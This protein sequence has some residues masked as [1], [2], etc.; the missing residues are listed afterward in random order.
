LSLE[1]QALFNSG[2]SVVDTFDLESFK[3]TYQAQ[4]QP[5]RFISNITN[6]IAYTNTNTLVQNI[7]GVNYNTGQNG[8]VVD[9]SNPALYYLQVPTGFGL[10][11]LIKILDESP[12]SEESDLGLTLAQNTGIDLYVDGV[13]KL[14]SI[15]YIY[16]KTAS[17]NPTITFTSGNIPEAGQEIAVFL[18]Y[19]NLIIPEGAGGNF[20]SLSE[21]GGT[22][23]IIQ[24]AGSYTIT[25][26][27]SPQEL[28][29]I[30][31]STP[32]AAG[33]L[34]ELRITGISTRLNFGALKDDSDI[35]TNSAEDLNGIYKV[36]SNYLLAEVDGLHGVPFYIAGT[37]DEIKYA[38]LAILET[39]PFE[40]TIDIYYETATQGLISS[41]TNGVE[42]PINYY[43]CINLKTPARGGDTNIV[44]QESRIKGGFNEPSMD[45]GVQAYLANE[46]Y[47]LI[48]RKSSLIY[49]GI[50][51][52]NTKVNNTNQFPSGENIVRTLDPVYG[53]IQKLY[54]D[55][56]DLLIFQEEKV[57]QALIDKD[58]IYTAEGQAL[59]TAGVNVIS[60]VNA[61]STNYGI[62]L[63]PKSFAVYAGRKYFVDKP[64]GAV[65]RLSRDG[66][67][68]ISN[69]GMRSEFRNILSNGS[70]DTDII[71]SWDMYNKEYVLSIQGSTYAN[72]EYGLPDITIGI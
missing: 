52:N 18:K 70:I 3:Y 34:E 15:D 47:G 1:N 53:S 57:S 13:K 50:L 67:T 8:L 12:F 24:S 64:K 62:G 33:N 6:V 69:Y 65:L 43:N 30:P 27:T 20:L 37:P 4:Q 10:H 48:T 49:S 2:S 59:T 26:P 11:K 66:I 38:D 28:P 35:Y 39:R 42:I 68:E 29:F 46:D 31:P 71:G 58:V 51:N 40:S 45:Y 32:F 21:L 7:N 17:P 44:W 23:S 14:G 55:T 56:D 5:E 60:Q 41:L 25:L 36:D 63:Y 72:S 9:G 54:A 16:N 19:N 61:Y 22:I